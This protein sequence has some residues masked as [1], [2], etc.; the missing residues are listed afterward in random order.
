MMALIWPSPVADDS[1][2]SVTFT[3]AQIPAVEEDQQYLPPPR[4]IKARVR[5]AVVLKPGVESGAV[6][7]TIGGNGPASIAIVP[8][9]SE[10]LL[11]RSFSLTIAVSGGGVKKEITRPFRTVWPDMP[12]SLKDIDYALDALKYITSEAEL[13]SLRTGNLENRRKNLESFWRGKDRTPGTGYNEVQT[14]YY[15]RVDHAMRSFGTLRQPDGFRSDRGRIYILY[16]PPST[17]ERSLGPV[18]GYQEVWFYER[19]KKK[20]TFVDESR[21][22]NYL[23]MTNP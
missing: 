7:Y 20:F 8:F 15:R 18:S 19:L 6:M 1:L 21:S 16:G 5:R 4:Q 3:F 17:T 22:G 12:F 10:R 11:L 14:E 2:I 9:P 13:D 23:L